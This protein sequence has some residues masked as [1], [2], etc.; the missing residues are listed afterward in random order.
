[1]QKKIL[2][3]VAGG[4]LIAVSL[5]AVVA[6]S[7]RAPWLRTQTIVQPPLT[8]SDDEATGPYTPPSATFAETVGVT[9][10]TACIPFIPSLTPPPTAAATATPFIPPTPTPTVTPTATPFIPPISRGDFSPLLSRWHR[11][12]GKDAQAQVT[13]T[14]G[15]LYSDTPEGVVL[16]GKSKTTWNFQP[17]CTKHD[18]VTG[19]CADSAAAMRARYCGNIPGCP[20]GVPPLVVRGCS[21]PFP[22]TSTLSFHALLNKQEDTPAPP[23]TTYTLTPGHAYI[24]RENDAGEKL[25]QGGTPAVYP[26]AACGLKPGERIMQTLPDVT[27]VITAWTWTSEDAAVIDSQFT[28]MSARMSGLTQKVNDHELLHADINSKFWPGALSAAFSKI[29]PWVKPRKFVV[30]SPPLATQLGEAVTRARMAIVA[31]AD[32]TAVKTHDRFHAEEKASGAGG[33]RDRAYCEICGS[34]NPGQCKPPTSPGG[35]GFPKPPPGSG[36]S[37][38]PPSGPSGFPGKF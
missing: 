2:L 32:D 38:F 15:L 12:F 19:K 8:E 29:D 28:G 27:T 3:G 16:P 25:Y 18:P 37:S 1:M 26:T 9:T 7:P 23:D 11:L 4:A 35:G 13:Y 34:L 30:G 10:P 20:A 33:L 6:V 17:L 14:C 24:C 21:Q 31:N 5:V 22:I 36:G